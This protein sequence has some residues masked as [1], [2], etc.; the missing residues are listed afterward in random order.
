MNY[1]H[2]VVPGNPYT[3]P[4]W[5]VILSRDG[6][7]D[8]GGGGGFL[9]SKYLNEGVKEFTDGGGESIN[10]KTFFGGGICSFHELGTL[11]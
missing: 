4:L 2:C 6:G 3:I 11:H 5:K 1:E 9:D 8:G 10:H 7:E